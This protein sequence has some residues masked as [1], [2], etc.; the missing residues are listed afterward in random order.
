MP[1][2]CTYLKLEGLSHKKAGPFGPA[3]TRSD[4]PVGLIILWRQNHGHEAAFS[5]GFKF[6][7]AVLGKI[8]FDARQ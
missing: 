6:D 4:N 8:F 1:A 3:E 7:F 2:S 5:F